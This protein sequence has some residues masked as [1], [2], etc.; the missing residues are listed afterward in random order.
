VIVVVYAEPD[1]ELIRII[2]ARPASKREQ[3]WY[4]SYMDGIA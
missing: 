1:E 2:S 3:D 4:R